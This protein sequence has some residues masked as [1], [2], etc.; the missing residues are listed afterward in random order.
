M[1]PSPVKRANHTKTSSFVRTGSAGKVFG[2]CSDRRY[3]SGS[4]P[5]SARTGRTRCSK[6]STNAVSN[7]PWPYQIVA[8]TS[9]GGDDGGHAAGSPGAC[10]APAGTGNPPRAEAGLQQQDVVGVG[11]RRVR[12]VAVR[13][14][15]RPAVEALQR[16]GAARHVV[17]AAEPDEPV[18]VVQVAELPQ[19]GHAHCLL[20]LDELPVEQLDQ[21]V[22]LSWAQC[23]L[24]Q[25]DDRTP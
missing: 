18:G 4:P 13:L 3:A 1:W 17:E 8:R 6:N 20:G 5:V 21:Y 12:L 25:F 19:D 9:G 23:V 14:P 10:R 24:P 16:L 22:P 11:H 2:A 15:D 7:G